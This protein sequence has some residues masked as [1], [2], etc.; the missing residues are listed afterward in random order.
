MAETACVRVVLGR[1]RRSCLSSDPGRPPCPRENKIQKNRPRTCAPRDRAPRKFCAFLR[2]LAPASVSHTLPPPPPPP[3]PP[4]AHPRTTMSRAH[5]MHVLRAATASLSPRAVAR[6]SVAAVHRRPAVGQRWYSDEKA[7][8]SEKGQGQGEAGAGAAAEDGPC[9]AVERKLKAKEEE[10]VD[11]TVR[12]FLFEPRLD[13]NA[14]PRLAR[15]A[16]CATSRPTSS[17]SSATPRARRSRPATLQ[18]RA[19]LATSSRPSTS[20]PSPSNPSPSPSSPHHPH[21]RHQT[22]PPPR[23]QRHQRRRRHHHHHHHHHHRHPQIQSRPRRTSR[24]STP[25]SRS[26][27]ACSSRRSSSTRSSPLTPP[28]TSSTPTATK[29]STRRPYR[30]RSPA[31]SSTA[32]RPVT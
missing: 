5:A 31:P 16:A 21:H 29:P 6:A 28:A 19:S 9:A 13:A 10:A 2:P 24:S 27:T 30:A 12:I 15:R 4:P 3:P 23:H 1:R 8:A 22:T 7:P 26:P 25:A 18:S 20:S 17:T 32:K 14:Y 11:L